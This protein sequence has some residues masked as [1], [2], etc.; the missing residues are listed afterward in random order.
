MM[1]VY[2]VAISYFPQ[3]MD[4]AIFKELHFEQ[5]MAYSLFLRDWE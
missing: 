3:G 2:V 1:G 5:I 4:T